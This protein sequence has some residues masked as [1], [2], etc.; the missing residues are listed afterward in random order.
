[1][2]RGPE[3]TSARATTRFIAA[4]VVAGA[5]LFAGVQLLPLL[6]ERPSAGVMPMIETEGVPIQSAVPADDAAVDMRVEE[7]D[8]QPLAEVVSES[9]TEIR[10]RVAAQVDG[11]PNECPTTV[12]A[13]LREPLGGRAVIDLSTGRRVER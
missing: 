3:S 1:M 5:V 8:G 7:C 11:D 2:A 13:H 9:A 12:R 10:V 6:D 4:L